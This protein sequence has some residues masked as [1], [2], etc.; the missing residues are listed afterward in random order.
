MQNVSNGVEI[1]R[2]DLTT[3]G[4]HIQRGSDLGEKAE[5]GV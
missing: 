5:A 3:I 1:S 4:P 2:D